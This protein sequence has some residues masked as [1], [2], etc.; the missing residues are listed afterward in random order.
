VTKLAEGAGKLIAA[1]I[2]EML[3]VEPETD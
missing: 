2:L 3:R 1:A